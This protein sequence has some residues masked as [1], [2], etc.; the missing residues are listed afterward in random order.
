[1]HLLTSKLAGGRG[2]GGGESPPPPLLMFILLSLHKHI[3]N[4]CMLYLLLSIAQLQIDVAE[5][6]YYRIVQEVDGNIRVCFQTNRIVTEP[7]A[8]YVHIET[9]SMNIAGNTSAI[10]KTAMNMYYIYSALT[11]FTCTKKK[12]GPGYQCTS[13]SH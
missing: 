4:M 2:Q 1:M 5:Y 10:G 11:S 13:S 3:C 7:R 12:Q 9:T 8:L 6:P